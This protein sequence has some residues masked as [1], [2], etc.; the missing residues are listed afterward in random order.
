MINPITALSSKAS[1]KEVAQV[2]GSAFVVFVRRPKRERPD[3]VI[4]FPR[5]R[6]SV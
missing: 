3:N 6:K 4:P 5:A 1:F 2:S